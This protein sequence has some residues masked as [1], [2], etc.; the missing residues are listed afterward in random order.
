VASLHETG[1]KG[2]PWSLN[3]SGVN[4][5]YLKC[6]VIGLWWALFGTIQFLWNDANKSLSPK[7]KKMAVAILIVITDLV[8]LIV[9]QK[10]DLTTLIHELAVSLI[11][12]WFTNQ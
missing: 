9:S 5:S 7:Q 12:N 2:Q 4:M 11:A 10:F 6:T 1:L 8:Y 3:I